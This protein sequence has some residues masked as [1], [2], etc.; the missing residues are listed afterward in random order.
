MLIVLLAVTDI[1]LLGLWAVRELRAKAH[2]DEAARL[3]ISALSDA[4]LTASAESISNQSGRVLEFIRN[5]QSESAAALSILG[6]CAAEDMG[7][8]ITQYRSALG[9]AN[10]RDRG[11]FEIV[12]FQ[13]RVLNEGEIG[14]LAQRMGL[15]TA[16]ATALER[17]EH[18]YTLLR[19]G[20][21][22][23]VWG[24]QA[25]F[26]T[27]G[28]GRLIG[29]EGKWLIGDS[30]ASAETQSR[31][32]GWALLSLAYARSDAGM[33]A[34]A[35]KEMSLGYLAESSSSGIMRL[36]PCWRINLT[37]DAGDE[38]PTYVNAV[39]GEIAAL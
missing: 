1:L 34:C 13:P 5:P 38:S 11:E 36:V 14:T 6:E 35:L 16:D 31:T 20:E 10:F 28:E 39:T 25:V 19:Y 27:D 32:S 8:G 23:P 4:G 2:R 24:E 26:L 3:L 15:G 30:Y 17:G 37:S 22:L 29:V 33:P 21:A 18:G 7:G 12:L 9:Y